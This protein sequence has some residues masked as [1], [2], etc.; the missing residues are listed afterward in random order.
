MARVFVLFTRR[1]P[2]GWH[3]GAFTQVP[4]RAPEKTGRSAHVSD[5]AMANSRDG[6]LRVIKELQDDLAGTGAANGR[7]R[8]S[9]ASP[10]PC[11]AF[12]PTSAPTANNTHRPTRLEAVRHGLGCGDR[13]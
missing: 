1:L 11:T 9:N 2:P 13:I 6:A 12:W 8:P 3:P 5:L 4:Q 10:T 7:I